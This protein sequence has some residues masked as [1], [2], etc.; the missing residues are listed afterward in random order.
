MD[1]YGETC[2]G[3][4]LVAGI[5]PDLDPDPAADDAATT[6]T[7]EGAGAT[8]PDTAANA[9]ALPEGTGVADAAVGRE[10]RLA[11][12]LREFGGRCRAAGAEMAG[13]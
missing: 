7:D 13:W 3:C 9:A 12:G 2:G 8:A 10:R 11:A 5:D 6:P 1:A 4:P